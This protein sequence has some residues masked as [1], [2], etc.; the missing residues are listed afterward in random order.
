MDGPLSPREHGFVRSRL[1]G[2]TCAPF[3]YQKAKDAYQEKPVAHHTIEGIANLG[4]INSLKEAFAGLL[5]FG[6]WCFSGAWC[7]GFGTCLPAIAI[8]PVSRYIP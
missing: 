5:V 6:A 3:R 7:L 4:S 1:R 8:A 2:S